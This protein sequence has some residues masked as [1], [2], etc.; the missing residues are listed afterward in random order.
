MRRALR[1]YTVTGV[2]T[3]VPFFRWLLEQ[4]TFVAGR[5]HAGG[6]D[7]VLQDRPEGAFAD[8]DSSLEEVALIA[9]ALDLAMRA[10][11]AGRDVPSAWA[12]LARREGLRA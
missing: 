8:R 11:A 3:T 5:V 9:A 10:H 1:E 4:P 6:L 7:E 2:R 12:S